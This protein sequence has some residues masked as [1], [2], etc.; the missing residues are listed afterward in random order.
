MSKS[1][2]E[3]LNILKEHN[4][5]IK[6]NISIDDNFDTVTSRIDGT[7]RLRIYGRYLKSMGLNSD[8]YKTL[9]PDAPLY[10]E[11]DAKNTNINKGEHMKKPEY[12]KMFSDKIKGEKNPNHKLNTTEQERKERSPFSDEFYKIHD[13]DKEE[14]VKNVL[15]NRTIDS[16]NTNIEYYL[17]KG[18]NEEEAKQKLHKR[19]QTFS[20][21]ICIEKYGYD[22]GRKIF[23]DR[24]HKW[25]NSLKNSIKLGYSKISQELFNSLLELYNEEDKQYIHYATNNSEIYLDKED[26]TGLYIY[27]FTDLKNM[28]MIEYQG[29]IYHANPNVY[30]ADEYPH[31]YQKDLTS[32]D[33]W[34]KDAEKK[35]LAYKNGYE[36]LIIWD[37]EFVD[38]KESV[39]NKC[40]QF[41]NLNYT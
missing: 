11:K 1:K 28:K 27:D 14:F 7:Q 32:E 8:D 6:E 36:L 37:S 23:N 26:G 29:D 15:E 21:E 9:F 2:E 41:L 12:K 18:F 17:K 25:Q 35:E 16:Y 33:I 3:I 20:L 10:A 39:I 5:T 31:P 13:G 38:N 34:N 30:E 22:E 24:Q 40:K 4:I 19:Q